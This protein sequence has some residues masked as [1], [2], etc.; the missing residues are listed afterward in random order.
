MAR[1]STESLV[2]LRGLQRDLLNLSETT[3]QNVTQLHDQLLSH[4]TD[5]RNILNKATRNETSRKK[6]LSGMLLT[7]H[8]ASP[9][10]SNTLIDKVQ[11]RDEEYSL[12]DDFKQQTLELSEALDLDEIES[13]NLLQD[14]NAA[15]EDLDRPAIITA[16]ISFQQ[17]R[18]YSLQCLRLSFEKAADAQLG[19]S[20]V[21]SLDHFIS[22]V[23]QDSSGKSLSESAYWR[24][25]LE[26]ME[27]M[28][29]WVER[30]S[31]RIQRVTVTEQTQSPEFAEVM[32]FQHLSLSQQHE[33]LGVIAFRL[34]LRG[35]VNAEA[36]R[37]LLQKL[38]S[39]ERYDAYLVH[40][41]PTLFSGISQHASSDNMSTAEEAKTL[42]QTITS[43]KE[44]DA[45]VLA[46]LQAA[47][48][49]VW[50]S[51]YS[52]RF[53]DRP[54]SSTQ[55]TRGSS[56]SEVCENCFHNALKNGAFQFLL[57]L[58][59]DITPKEW[60]DPA[61]QGFH[62][63]L[64]QDSPA[65][66]IDPFSVQECLQD[67]VMHCLQ[68]FAE[69][70]ITNMPDA[71]RKLKQE[72]D[73]QRRQL[74]GRVP[75]RPGEFELHLERFLLLIS[76][77]YAGDVESADR[78]WSGTES[79][80]YGFLQWA[81]QRQ[82][83]PRVA[84]F[85]E[86]LQTLSGDESTADHA[87]GFLLDDSQPSS[88]RP[89]R[90][91]PLSWN[92][93]FRELEYYSSTIR[94][95]PASQGSVSFNTRSQPDLTVEPESSMMLESYLR[96]I[97]HLS[98]QSPDARG[99]LLK[100]SFD[101]IG[102]L[103]LLCASNIPSRL[104]ACAFTALSGL[105]TQK[106]KSTRDTLWTAIDA[107]LYAQPSV[108]VP[109]SSRPVPLSNVSNAGAE[110][111]ILD[112]IL[113]G[114]E[115]PNAFVGLIISLV[116]PMVKETPIKDAIPFPEDLGSKYR[117]SGIEPYVDFVMGS[118]LGPK[119]DELSDPLQLR[120]MRYRCLSFAVA[121]LSD[122][123]EDLIVLANK[124]NIPVESAIET[125]S[126]SAYARLH[127]FAR[128]ME[129]LFNERVITAVFRA[130]IQNIEEVNAAGT[131]SPLILSL[132][133]S[134]EVINLVLDLQRSYFDI[135]RPIIKKQFN[136]RRQVVA[137]AA[138]ASFEDA[139]VGRLDIITALG[140]YC[141]SG[142][143]DLAI[144][145]LN[146]LRRLS[147]SRKLSVSLPRASA[148]A[149]EKSRLIVAL[150]K[151]H[152]VDSISRALAN[153]MEFDSREIGTEPTSP[154]IVIK[155]KILEF[156]AS[157]LD[158]VKESPSVAHLLLGFACSPSS[159]FLDSDSLFGSQYSLFDSVMRFSSL[160]PDTGL[161]DNFY[162]SW[163]LDLRNK[164][165]LIMRRLW[166]SSLSAG[167]VLPE[168]RSND[169]FC[170]QAVRFLPID[171]DTRWDNSSIHDAQFWASTS[172]HGYASFLQTRSAL[173][174]LAAIELR[175]AHETRAASLQARILSSLVGSTTVM[176]GEAF[177]NAT[178]FDLLDFVDLNDHPSFNFPLSQYY[179]L[180]M[181][182]ACR[183]DNSENRDV[184]DMES[185]EQILLLKQ[186]ELLRVNQTRQ[187]GSDVD[188]QK[189]YDE[190]EG[191]RIYLFA[192]NAKNSVVEARLE[193]LKAWINLSTVVLDALATSQDQQQQFITQLLQLVL[194]KLERT[195]YEDVPSAEILTGFAL[196]L[197]RTGSFSTSAK[198][199]GSD[200][201]DADELFFE[202]FRAC[203]AGIQSP[204]ASSLLRQLCSHTCRIFICNACASHQSFIRRILQTTKFF[205][206]RLL[207]V[208]CEDAS[209]GDGIS[210]IS[211]ILLLEALA[212]ASNLGGSNYVV[213]AL[214]RYNF[215]QIAVKSVGNIPLELQQ[216]NL[217]GTMRCY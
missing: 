111:V 124:A 159:I 149:A 143:A 152:D 125:S 70:V 4:I 168:L 215:T 34:T 164:A 120:I 74:Q 129:W 44:N 194:P 204:D 35:Q 162:I 182:E 22:L 209:E 3:V 134:L 8:S 112:K 31:E 196:T 71:L 136:G 62:S 7:P 181:F 187:V 89:R 113:S 171:T 90:N 2:S 210:R 119:S 200:A 5:F 158:S 118:V 14:A 15:S 155:S 66:Q 160:I 197:A 189:L 178:I 139:I 138:L 92:H 105:L 30:V 94:D 107:W 95:K 190:A 96:L 212:R 145:S 46:A 42:H 131:Q 36:L 81:S 179:N 154:G 123:N 49:V 153:I 16:I 132:L 73:E 64:V 57:V 195:L 51:D 191:V 28:E 216:T 25:C 60:Y 91:S 135:V 78:Y 121:C 50:I 186:N 85:C 203:L 205:G 166:R 37:W 110:R 214:N 41:L 198:D 45:W 188:M 133:K 137:N 150:E 163:L 180:N 67:A 20:A 207:E 148:R 26:V 29:Q 147:Q 69:S 106:S 82:S 141:A 52:I 213:N 12:N 55:D 151:D 202:L 127:P 80:L 169:Y 27:E 142:H 173:C 18:Q 140:L 144:S 146:L 115:E 193:A 86:V 58:S 167:L 59:Y 43:T 53:S 211:S 114:F 56:E 21:S 217:R 54:A 192:H 157:S 102:N 99:W 76:N 84:A 72:E 165:V 68:E 9:L 38:K 83:T 170:S 130:A 93:I 87:H 117:M 172:A 32:E 23:L 19:D 47:V 109:L 100:G 13:A 184:Y 104:R 161:E 126:L 174:E 199:G 97:A 24:R 108:I 33:E 17:I 116:E 79:N 101:I 6:L 177:T 40:K 206:E 88:L 61:K 98:T 183:T 175:S 208:I 176:D 65:L 77:A 10:L 201:D 185:V 75:M 156:L 11:L 128:M 103:L 39:A 48:S 63:F 122:F 1:S